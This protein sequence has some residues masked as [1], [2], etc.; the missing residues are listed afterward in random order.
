MSTGDEPVSASNLSAVVGGVLPLIDAL[1]ARVAELESRPS[2][3]WT[4]SSTG[5]VSFNQP[6]SYYEYFDVYT[7]VGTAFGLAAED[8]AQEHVA[9]GVY[10]FVTDN[11]SSF[12]VS[13][14][15]MNAAITRIDGYESN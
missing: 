12:H 15:G 9:T 7:S 2:T 8:D 10:V 5:G 4:G 3:I 11:E 1:E 13:I 6:L 14:R